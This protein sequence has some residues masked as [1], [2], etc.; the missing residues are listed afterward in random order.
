MTTASITHHNS[1]TLSAAIA[2]FVAA[3]A[4]TGVAV[5]EHE[6]G[7]PAPDTTHDAYQYPVYSISRPWH[8]GIQRGMP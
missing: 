2:A 3:V 5:A 6:N 7:S 4:F 8:S 1:F